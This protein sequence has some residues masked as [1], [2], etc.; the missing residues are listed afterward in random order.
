MLL[1]AAWPPGQFAEQVDAARLAADVAAL[2]SV[3][4]ATRVT[5]SEGIAEA[6]RWLVARLE[7]LGLA[8]EL[9]GFVVRHTFFGRDVH[10]ANVVVAFG[11]SGP[12]LY[13]VAHLDSKAAHDREDAETVG[14]RAARD[15]AP[16]ADD[17]ASGAAALLEVARILK[18][19]T[20]RRVVLAW[21]DAEEMSSMS[22]DG[23]MTNL[24]SEPLARAA[25][26]GAQAIA[27][28]MLL[29]P[30]PWGAS[31]RIYEDG[32]VSSAAL[33]DALVQASWIVA[34]EVE[35]RP[36]LA[37]GFTWSDHGSFW[38]EGL[39][40][41]LLI[42]DDFEHERYH[43]VTDRLAPEDAFYSVEQLTAATR[44]LV[45]AVVLLG[46]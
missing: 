29:R 11:R 40:A 13:L 34:P 36:R 31:L 22:D 38:A 9:E 35:V 5:G 24:G 16:G 43:R 33:R 20:E 10:A 28:D 3:D 1:A 17:D 4:G 25:P 12:P 18:G 7:A 21:V 19:R 37:P 23:F 8:P 39:G 27:V 2:Q 46:G 6:R 30:R 44:V 14:W 42:E 15:P 26:D 41:V 32:R 45:A